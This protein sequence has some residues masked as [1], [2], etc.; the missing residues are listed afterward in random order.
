MIEICSI[1]KC[2]NNETFS[3]LKLWVSKV[4]WHFDRQLN[5]LYVLIT[6]IGWS[7]S[8]LIE[9]SLNNSWKIQ[10]QRM[11]W[12]FSFYLASSVTET[13]F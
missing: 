1:N 9:I 13:A 3:L 6:L 4:F 12:K 8:E 2:K 7:N 5:I 11:S 10:I